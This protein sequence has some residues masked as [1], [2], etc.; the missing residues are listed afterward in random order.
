MNRRPTPRRSQVT[1]AEQL[2]YALG[3]VVAR[4]LGVEQFDEFA[5]AVAAMT[6]LSTLTEFGTEKYAMRVL[7]AY[8]HAGQWELARGYCRFASGLILLYGLIE[9]AF[10][11][12]LVATNLE[13]AFASGFLAPAVMDAIIT[14]WTLLYFL[15][16]RRAGA[17]PGQ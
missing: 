9:K 4:A 5:V 10:M 6:M 1:V 11:V 13:Q 7:P 17:M 16:R 2:P 15:F 12:F 14:I 8:A 3:I